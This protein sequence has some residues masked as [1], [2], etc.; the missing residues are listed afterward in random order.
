MFRRMLISSRSHDPHGPGSVALELLL[1]R[2]RGDGY[3]SSLDERAAAS[4]PGDDQQYRPRPARAS[5][6][7]PRCSRADVDAAARHGADARVA[8]LRAYIVTAVRGPGRLLPGQRS[9]SRWNPHSPGYKKTAGLNAP[10]STSVTLSG[11]SSCGRGPYAAGRRGRS[12][13]GRARSAPER[14]PPRR[15]RPP[16]C[17]RRRHRGHRTLDPVDRGTRAGS[18]PLTPRVRK[19]CRA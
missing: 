9:N 1:R 4:P 14:P 15:K 7:R 8:C 5:E 6:T 17:R 12:P 19:R 13:A 3:A 18:S 11:L 2:E 16:A 10:P